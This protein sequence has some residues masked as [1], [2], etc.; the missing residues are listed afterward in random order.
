MKHSVYAL[1]L[2]AALAFACGR[3]EEAPSSET[4]APA[5]GPAKPAAAI[6]ASTAAT[7]SGKV[8]FTGAKPAPKKIRMEQDKYCAAQHPGGS[9]E[10]E[11]VVVNDNGTLA[12]VFVWVEE[13]LGDRSF[14]ASTQP[15]TLDQKGCRYEP[16]VLGVMTG[17]P[18][19]IV[20]SDNT[21]HNIHPM[22]KNNPEWNEVQGPGAP[23][24][25]KT[26]AREE[27]LIPV[28][29]NI[30]P[31]M[32]AYIGVVKNPFFAVTGKDGTF[33]IKG[34]PPGSYTVAA[35]HEKYNKMEQKVTVAAKEAKTVDFSFSGK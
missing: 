19:D 17:Q 16:H 25:T 29:C 7:V 35:W 15:A 27:L 3:K 24:K 20:S 32:K 5:T 23:K 4:A 21:N 28:K 9:I 11:D 2:V 26:F 13:G 22:P 34:L 6:D 8:N 10:T 12:N 33:E 18:L 30:H 1:L 14:E 31:W